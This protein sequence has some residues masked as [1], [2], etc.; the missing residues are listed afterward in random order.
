MIKNFFALLSLISLASL[1]QSQN[2][3][4]GQI[5]THETR[6]LSGHMAPEWRSLVPL[7]RVAATNTLRLAISLPLQ[8][9]A[10]LEKLIGELYDPASTNYHR[11]LTPAEFTA[12]FG[13][14]LQQYQEVEDFA[15]SNH[16]KILTRF[17]NR[18]LMD[19]EGT[20]AD[21]EQAFQVSLHEY[22]HPTK[23]R[24]FFGPD[25][26]PTVDL[27]LPILHVAGLNNY[28]QPVPH[29]TKRTSSVTTKANNGSGP[30][31]N[32]MGADFRHAYAPGTSLNGAGQIVGL[33]QFDGYAASDISYYFTKAG[34]TPITLTNVLIGGATGAASGNGGEVEVCLDIEMVASMA[35]GVSS[36][37]LFIAPNATSPDYWP[38][39]INA[40]VAHP[41]VKQ[42]SCSWGND[43][44]G[45][46]PAA[47][48]GFLQM[49]AQ[50][51][52]FFNATGD[53]DA[54]SAS[55]PITF[56][57]D[58]TNVTEVGATTLAMNGTGASY[59]S[60]TVWQW[61]LNSGSYV[62]SSG[63]I[64][65]NFPIPPW[66]QG[67]SM[68]ANQGS[69]TARD[70]P[71]VACC[72]DNVYVRADG[73][74]QTGTGGTSCAA[75]LW[76]GFTALVNQQSA[77]NG[78]SSVGFL[79]PALYTVG[80]SASFTN[81]FHDISTGNNT[82]STSKTKFFAVA[83]YDL[84]TGWGTPS[85]TNLINA[86]AP[87]SGPATILASPASQT[88]IYG[89][90]ATFSV[91]AGGSS[92][93]AYQWYFTN[94]I[95]GATNASLVLNTLTATNAGNY[96][97]I[98][99]NA[100]GSATSA[101]A[102]LTVI[103]A[104]S[105]TQSPVSQSNSYGATVTFTANAIG[106]AP[107]AYQWYFTN[108]VAGATNASL[109]IANIV[110][111]N[112]GNYFVVA[113]N[114][115]GSATSAVA[116][117]T[118][119]SSPNITQSP[120]SQSILTGQAASFSVTAF[121]A[122]P[123]TYQWFFTNA[124]AGATNTSLVITNVTATNAG[125]YFVVVTNTYGSATSSVATLT[126]VNPA[127]YSGV[128]AGW[129]MNALPG[130]TGDF[131][132]SPFSPTTNAPNITVIG[133]TRGSGVGTSGYAAAR[134]WGGSG[135]NSTGEAAAVTANQFATL[136]LS[137]AGGYAVSISS[138]SQFVYRRSSSGPTSGVL[139]Y[140]I[141]S[142]AFTDITNL[143]YTSS[144]S[145]GAVLPAIDLSGISALQN[146]P[147]GTTVTFRLMNFGGSS[148]TGT[149][150]LY[151][152]ST[153]GVNDFEI[154]GALSPSGTPVN[155]PPTVTT[156]AASGVTTNAAV[157]NGTVN[158]NN[159]T[160]AAQFLYGLT[161]NYNLTAAVSGPFTGGSA[162]AVS[163]NLTGLTPATTY[164]FAITAT[165]NSGSVTG[166]D[167][168][169][170]TAS[171]NSGSSNNGT[172][173]YGLLAG[174]D[175]SGLS[176]YGAS[177][178]AATTN[179]N[180]LSIGGLIRGGGVGTTGSAAG[181]AW[182]GNTFNSSTEASAITAGQ[183]ATFSLTVTNGGTLTVSNLTRFD[184]RRSTSG[185][186]NGMLQVSIAGGAF[187]DVTNF[188]YTST[189]SSGASLGPVDLSWN[190]NLQNIAAGTTVTFRIVNYG[191]NASGGTWYVYDLAGSTALDF[192]LSGSI[193]FPVQSQ[194]PVIT[195]QPVGT[196]AIIG[197][198]ATF[199]VAATGGSLTYQWYQGAS[200]INNGT[201]ATL[202]LSNLAL[203]DAG[204]YSVQIS[205]SAGTTN[206]ATAV[207]V[208]S[209][210]FYFAYDNGAGFFSGENLVHDDLSG[211]AFSVWSTTNI[212]LAVT[213]WSLEGS[214]VEHPVVG[215][216]PAT[217][218]Y[219]ITVTPTASP[220][221]Y[222]FARTNAG[223]YLTVQP[224]AWLTTSDYT[225]F[226]VNNTNAPIS[227]GGVFTLVVAPPAAI[228]VTAS[229]NGHNLTLTWS[230]S[231]FALQFATNVAGPYTTVSGATSPYT[232]PTTNTT[233]FFRLSN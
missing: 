28:A 170:T 69:T 75:P 51:Q 155:T 92:P 49:K 188:S 24:K 25:A 9:Q 221:F 61:G 166:L 20:A 217:S 183:Y 77:A 109:V 154:T 23:H 175:V 211:L 228:P 83:G 225:T 62:G 99:T 172:N 142:G 27:A 197:G 21:V 107:L 212:S 66:Q 86:L 29:Y 80:K 101:V 108:A 161:T 186:P 179:A 181:R 208:V 55:N 163:A 171:M 162:Q 124:I 26:E 123:L 96:F 91:T 156:S 93:L 136:A 200:T 164:H 85:G 152:Q 143:S 11:F 133:L 144:S 159:Q 121:G 125:N 45:A 73:A 122:P 126:A 229:L 30:S 219:G 4:S 54:F 72:G 65:T 209:N 149:W 196:N 48:Q 19:V 216:S 191:A 17:A 127:A 63:G 129:D 52:T 111:T 58:S 140:Q 206:S 12:R 145:S 44:P 204:N 132:A 2:L 22:E 34:I 100:Y 16:L 115:F 147:S 192:S 220:T 84:C 184:Y 134:G 202:V 41:E 87:A 98:V 104:P 148:S 153:P 187:V 177:P 89:G 8:N 59:A 35:P 151:D 117:L 160:T 106:G 42:F 120:A 230:N 64:S 10:A 82:N 205:N 138:V 189:S 232:V 103:T 33:L 194:P 165:N 227:N 105:I 18:T 68:T 131:G 38:D 37:M 110:A 210:Q 139:Q 176:G 174:W 67:V 32:Y 60:E 222:I 157:L 178:Y 70:V 207:L 135:F 168:T 5:A 215:S 76:A 36:I 150:Y 223:P 193:I 78:S 137:A 226:V 182:G 13:P 213:S 95:P 233:G 118:V 224:V 46:E 199:S 116:S 195:H 50:G 201:N 74:D 214:A 112:A 167:Q 88:N 79:N 1:I 231:A 47:E 185:P 14:S 203:S 146:V 90:T 39:L 130:G 31:S 180:G 94:A 15:K 198:N 141:G 71:D 57:S 6:K 7:N 102:R 119:V 40:M 158:P 97:V 128:L 114:Q 56:P 43:T 53:S 81:C 218:H 173:Y 169:F 190:T 3:A 113:S